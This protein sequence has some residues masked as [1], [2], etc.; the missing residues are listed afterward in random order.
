[1]SSES[2][3]APKERV[4]IT[5]KA[6]TSG[7]MAEIELPNKMLVL[8]DFTM[9]EED[10]VLEDREKVSIDKSNFNDVMSKHELNLSFMVDDHISDIEDGQ[11]REEM[12]VNLGFE[13]IKS[14]EP[15][16]VVKQVPE[17]NKLLQLR[18]ALAFLKGPLGNIPAFRKQLDSLLDDPASRE[19]LM[20][21]LEKATNKE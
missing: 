21:E 19:K 2:S 15:E 6:A 10:D 1:M 12:P 18:D 8:G 13:N 9:R 17:L 14:F 4:N 11:E 5:Y 3:V 16:Q 20:Q 7:G